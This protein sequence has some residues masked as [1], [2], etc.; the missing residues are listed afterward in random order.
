MRIQIVSDIHLER[1]PGLTFDQVIK[2]EGDVLCLAGDI[3]CPLDSAYYKFLQQCSQAFRHTI[4]VAGNHE[5]RRSHPL[6]M[7]DVD[8]RLGEMC[9]SLPNVSY[10]AHGANLVIDD[11]HF[12]GATMWTPLYESM[13]PLE[14]LQQLEG[15]LS[16]QM[17]NATTR[18][19]IAQ[20]NTTHTAHLR[21]IDQKVRW[22]VENMKKNVV[23]THH[24]PLLCGPFE[25][26]D[27]P[28]DYLYGTDLS[29]EI[30]QSQIAAWIYG[31]THWN[32]AT[33]L[34]G[35]QVCSNQYGARG[36]QGWTPSCVI[37]V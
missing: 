2:P 26:S 28:N 8:M 30:T 9:R 25:K 27:I 22:G 34:N 10:L 33:I 21:E 37:H 1:N 13:F 14:R 7:H 16:M 15:I 11:V 12:I 6:T 24:S 19:G 20:N 31:H 3:G 29:R 36:I 32:Y 18:W 17:M 4:L 35:T 23:I 5:Y